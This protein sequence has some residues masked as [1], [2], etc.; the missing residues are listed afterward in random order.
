[1]IGASPEVR[2]GL[3]SAVAILKKGGQTSLRHGLPEGSKVLIGKIYLGL[4]V[5][6]YS[7]SL[8]ILGGRSQSQVLCRCFS[9]FSSA[10]FSIGANLQGCLSDGPLSWFWPSKKKGRRVA[11]P[12]VKSDR[13]LGQF[14]AASLPPVSATMQAQSAAICDAKSSRLLNS[15]AIPLS[16]SCST[17][18]AVKA[19]NSSS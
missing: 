1:M 13:Q 16:R 3:K 8:G 17:L 6:V 12:L 9:G 11:Q 4:R 2:P 10:G 14:P 19:F 18:A 7:E 15:G 5:L